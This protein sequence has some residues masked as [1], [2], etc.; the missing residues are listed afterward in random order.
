MKILF[1]HRI[2]SRDGQAVHL[3]EM[4][5][6]LREQGHEILLVGPASFE[7]VG[8][9]G[10]SPVV[11]RIK[12]I[13]PAPAYEVLELV[14]NLLAF[15]RL[16]KAV[17]SFRPDFIYERFSLFLLAG[18]WLHRLRGTP[19]LLEVN[20]PLYEER[21]RH[22]GL[23][24][25]GL[26]RRC[27]AYIWRNVDYVLP[28][29][30][31]L[32]DQVHGYGVP[33]ERIVVITN[34]INRKRFDR[35]PAMA[36]AKEDAGLSGR[37]VLGFTGFVR[38]WHA[39]D[40]VIDFLADHGER[41]N[42]HLLIVGDGPSRSDLE[43]LAAARNVSHRFTIT[44]VIERDAVAKHVATFDVALLPGINDYASPLKLF[45]YMYLGKAVV[46]P[47]QQNIREILTDE[48][49]ALL[50]DPADPSTMTLAIRR[51]S[52][53]GA[54]RAQIGAG[55]HATLGEKGLYWSNNASK[56]VALAN[57]LNE[58]PAA[59]KHNA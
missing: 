55:S 58:G 7:K 23:S 54:L 49:D 29:T 4:I 16:D 40:K 5:D 44:G 30:A 51:L 38:Q 3:E 35:A 33:K 24:L 14:Y 15:R 59:L 8:F 41:L 6:A 36:Q 27:Q 11:D 39:M 21:L 37:L 25:R 50:F 42:L 26:A 13:I 2:A 56:V 31:V 43:A 18:T 52:E 46:A 22:D 1:H 32:A 47:D 57:N 17:R 53:D 48:K 12:R 34:G 28:V 10:S 20:G 45:E 9:G 19:I